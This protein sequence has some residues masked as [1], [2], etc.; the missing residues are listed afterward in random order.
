MAWRRAYTDLTKAEAAK[1][2]KRWRAQTP[3][4]QLR[5]R[6][7]PNGRHEIWVMGKN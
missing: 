1:H 6:K 2:M 3:G 4:V 5:L 7:D